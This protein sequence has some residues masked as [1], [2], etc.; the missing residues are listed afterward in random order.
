MINKESITRILRL[1]DDS[2]DVT[3]VQISSDT[4][5]VTLQKKDQVM[6]CTE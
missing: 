4:I 5:E 6:F 2:A 3:D 1:G